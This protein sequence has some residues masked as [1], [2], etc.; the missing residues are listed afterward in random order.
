MPQLQIDKLAYG[1]SGF[2][3]LDG[4]ACFVPFTAPGDLIE[5]RIEKSKSS[6]SEG[7]VEELLHPSHH[8]APPPCPVFGVCGGCN[9]QHIS[10]LEQC[11][12]KENI[13]ADTLWRS[14]RIERDK[15]KPILST[16]SPFGYRQ[17]IQLKVD[18]SGSRFSLGF[19]RRNSH[20]V[21]DIHDYCMI[22][23]KP[24]NTAI[25][26]LREII[27]SFREG[28]LLSQVE[29]AA[30]SDASVSAVFHYDGNNPEKFAE[31]LT[32]AVTGLPELHSFSI[33]KGSRR[34]FQHVSGLEKLRYS[35]PSSD[36]ID[37]DL[38]YAPD[39][40]SQVN[41]TQNR[42]MVQ[43]LL[44]YCALASPDS[45]LD[46]YSGNGNFSLPLARNVKNIL[47]FESVKKS[48]SLAQYNATV[49]GI[50]N[51]EYICRDSAAGVVDLAKKPGQFELIIMDPPRTG[52]NEVCKKIHKIGSSQLIYISCDPPT[53]GRD[54]S[55]LQKTGFEVTSIQPVDMF[56]QTYHLESIVFLKSI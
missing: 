28:G 5:V 43:L 27:G 7:I 3:R 42:A 12:Q 17:R 53:L 25:P 39:S 16:N 55:V 30:S 37:L 26:K 36:Q 31:Y 54:I 19:H 11:R 21:I 33:K 23:A 9:W 38:Y 50:I 41:F 14:A 56:P 18:Y 4:K 44:D 6:Y 35:I 13:F 51:A 8:R 29:L 34:A 32:G 2:G 49:N 47:G 45:I 40:F 52:A 48:V 20:D 22:A 24:L 46:L 15:I 10:Y 1:G